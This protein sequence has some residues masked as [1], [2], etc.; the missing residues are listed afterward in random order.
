VLLAPCSNFDQLE[1]PI[2]ADGYKR[3]EVFVLKLIHGFPFYTQ[4][5][6]NGRDDLNS[7]CLLSCITLIFFH[8]MLKKKNFQM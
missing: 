1:M 5:I 2:E 6:H 4:D 3:T 7:L 8:C